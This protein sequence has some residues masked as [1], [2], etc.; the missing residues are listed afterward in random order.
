MTRNFSART[1]LRPRYWEGAVTYNG[2]LHA[3]PV[4]GVGYLEM[5]GY[6]K[7]LMRDYE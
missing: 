5:T 6:G 7:P 3:Q 4:Q 2:Y 1:V